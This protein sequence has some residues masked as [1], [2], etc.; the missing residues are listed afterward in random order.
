MKLKTNYSEMSNQ[1]LLQELSRRLT[2]FGNSLPTYYDGMVRIT[3]R[4]KQYFFGEINESD[5]SFTMPPYENYDQMVSVDV[6]EGEIITIND[7]RYREL[8]ILFLQAPFTL[9][10]YCEEIKPETQQDFLEDYDDLNEE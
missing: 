3:Y 2:V 5:S 7:P 9:F 8:L 10:S 4:E 1:E 6:G